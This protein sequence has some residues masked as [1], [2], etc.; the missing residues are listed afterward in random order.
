M[1]ERLIILAIFVL[2]VVT[3]MLYLVR[4]A[5][6]Q[7]KTAAIHEAREIAYKLMVKAEKHLGTDS[8]KLK[9]AYVMDRFWVLVPAAFKL[10]VSKRDAEKFLQGVYDELKDYMDD[11]LNNNS[12]KESGTNDQLANPP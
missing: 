5:K 8:G 7:G 9:M 1:A 3:L 10:I 11:G 2:V 12:D 6:T 4:I